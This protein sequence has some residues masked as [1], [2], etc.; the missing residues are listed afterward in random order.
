MLY[1]TISYNIPTESSFLQGG[2]NY[3][4]DYACYYAHYYAQY[5]G[6]IMHSIMRDSLGAYNKPHIIINKT[7]ETEY[8]GCN[9][10]LQAAIR[11]SR[12]R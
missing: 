12:L 3:A 1:Y 11:M 8:A 4:L 9:V 2:R 6:N 7:I 10:S 5:Y